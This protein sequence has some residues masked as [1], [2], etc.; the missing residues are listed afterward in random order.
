MI[1]FSQLSISQ[2][3]SGLLSTKFS[4]T[5]IVN[6]F[7]T[8]INSLDPKIQAFIT[9]T[10]DLAQI[11]A[12]KIDQKIKRNQPLG[13]LAGSV[14]AVKDI[15]LT[16]GVQTTAGSQLLKGYLPQY[17]S[18][19]YKKLIKE[20]SIIIGKTNTDTFAFGASTENSGYFT[21][22][23][24]WNFHMV[25]GGSS[26]GSA[27]AQSANFCTFALGTDTGGSIRQ[28]A[29]LCGVSGIKPTYGRNSRFGITSMASSFDCPGAFA[30][31]VA[32]LA[33]ITQV[34][35]GFD[36]HDAT[37]S[38]QPVPNY[39]DQLDK[40][41]LRG[42]KI[43]LPSEYFTSQVDSQ[44]R[45]QV[46]LAIDVFIKNGAIVKEISLPSTSLGID[47]YY[48]LVP[49]EIS[50]NMSRYDG[51]RFGQSA[52]ADNLI[53]SYFATRGQFMEAELKRRILIGTYCLSSGYYDAYYIQAAKVRTIIKQEFASA[54]KDVDIILTPV[55]PTTAWPIGEKINDP[56]QMY[57][58][59][60]LTVN[61]NVAGLPALALP[62]GLADN[63]LPVGFQLIGNYFEEDKLFS[64]GY[65]FQQHTDFHLF[66]PKL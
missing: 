44:V 41:S 31:T 27:A 57:L 58:A 35:A 7:L 55:S 4:A 12:K 24:P 59:D 34:T 29:S 30:H 61:V 45:R 47:V 63:G 66:T 53:D 2:I 54:F 39:L 26:G 18:T 65:Q 13:L 1:D 56:L 36:Q 43:G 49:C 64:L 19:V 52:P 25:P 3:R 23:N 14:M 11:Q 20:D 48:V 37:T 21:T 28:P 9:I 33:Q 32:D 38:S 8:R 22:K 10:K 15:Y 16:R 51:L 62:C 50:A 17:S 42:L 6:F 60:V 40:F 5:D 46:Q